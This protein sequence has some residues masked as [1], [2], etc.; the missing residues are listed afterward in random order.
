MKRNASEL[1]HTFFVVK[2][3][4]GYK[5][6]PSFLAK[7]AG[8]VYAASTRQIAEDYIKCLKNGMPAKELK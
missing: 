3:E 2:S 8:S 5:I 1:K 7:V 6:K 4:N